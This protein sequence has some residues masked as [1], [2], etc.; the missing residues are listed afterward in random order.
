VAN[1]KHPPTP[2]ENCPYRMDAP[3]RHWDRAE[4]EGVLRHE[5][6]IEAGVGFGAVYSCHKHGVLPEAERG[7]CAGWLL[8][9]RKRGL[10]SIA[11]RLAL[12]SERGAGEALEA[13]SDGGHPMFRTVKAMCRANGVRPKPGAAL[14]AYLRARRRAR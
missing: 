8:D 1:R 6:D 4:F 2:C 9:Q 14:P 11:L 12:I 7:M 10:P 3:R 5:A 13:V